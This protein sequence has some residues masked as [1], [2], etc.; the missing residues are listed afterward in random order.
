[1]TSKFQCAGGKRWGVLALGISALVSSCPSWAAP[2]DSDSAL[3]EIVV[4]S[5]PLPIPLEE[6]GQPVTIL[7]GSELTLRG[8]GTLGETLANQPG[9][10]QSYFGPGASRPVIRGLGGDRIRVLENGVGTLDVSNTSP[11]HAV[12]VESTTVRKIEV[13]RGPS[14]LLYGT[15]AVGGVV[16]VF[17]NRIPEL[18]PVGPVNGTAEIRGETVNQGRSGV[19]T[20]EAP[21]GP[22]AL[23]FDAFAR[24]TD[25]IDIPGFARAPAL[26]N[27]EAG[28]EENPRGSLPSSHTDVNQYS[29]G[30]S[31]IFDRG[32]VGAS[33]SEFSTLYGVPNG[34]PDISIDGQRRRGDIRAK[35]TQL[36]DIVENA[37]FKI[38]IV[39]YDH[40]E[41]EGSE[42]GTRFKQDGVDARLELTHAE[43]G[44]LRGVVGFQVQTSDFAAIGEEAFQPPTET[45]VLSAFLME[46]IQ[47]SET[48]KFQI[49][50]RYDRSDLDSRGFQPGPDDNRSELFD[51]FSQSAG[52]VWSPSERYSYSLSLARTERAPSGQELFANGPH[53]A[54]A[55]FEVGDPSLAAERSVGVDLQIK[56]QTGFV[57]GS[58]GG[59]VNYFSNY[60]NLSPTSDFEDDLRVYRFED[61]RARLMGV[62]SQISFHPLDEPG[63]K[64][65]FDFQPDYVYAENL[66][67][68]DALP[69]IQPF[70][71]RA[72]INYEL[73]RLF[74]ARVEWQQVFR[75]SRTSDFETAT[76]H[77]NT[78]NVFLSREFVV[79]GQ[80]F[81]L[82]V[83]G[84][85]LLNQ[86]AREHV[87]FIKDLAPLPGA[88]VLA[89]VRVTF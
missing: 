15:S 80:A 58:L 40:T 47:A 14:A 64:F 44:P 35:V 76:P 60:I 55:A 38:G 20:L 78:L 29:I 69:R 87:S 19:V 67:G 18:L 57:R 34:E 41:F 53:I 83:R 13:L 32:F 31:Y 17:D 81:E 30:G 50:G 46:E 23:H 89:G 63:Q 24:R 49:G 82:F 73:E 7:E 68:N 28:S 66:S 61:I 45:A 59:F 84:T 36:G 3:D 27:D 51:N 6:S 37:S 72:G 16:N 65:S 33:F 9:V 5:A 48:V 22:F 75:Q 52:V 1:M 12:A 79:E 26:R 70:R 56:K 21:I 71:M 25:D 11:D 86:K 54:T 77:Y 43:V 88:S 8:G 2:N 85:N 10:S 42:T 74:R 39:D 62:E 4:E